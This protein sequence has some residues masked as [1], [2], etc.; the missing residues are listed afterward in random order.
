MAEVER[1][2]R[3]ASIEVRVEPP[4]SATARWC[5]GEYFRELS[6]R[7]DTGFDPA[8]SNPASEAEMTPP[9]GYFVVAWLD[10]AAIGCGALKRGD[11]GIGEI[12]RM[13][14]SPAARGMGVARKVLAQLEAIAREAG[15]GVLRLETNRTLIEAQALYRSTGYREVPRFN[16][17]PYAHHWFEKRLGTVAPAPGRNRSPA[18]R[19][20]RSA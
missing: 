1:L 17:E 3:A 20:H 4:G 9:A 7:F 14:T 15:I 18:R 13:W 6:E 5:L 2:I 19:P 11:A 16:D 12:K 10:G 8:R